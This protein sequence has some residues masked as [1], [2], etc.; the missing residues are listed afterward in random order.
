[1][2]DETRER[3]KPG[4]AAKKLSQLHSPCLPRYKTSGD[5]RKECVDF[6]NQTLRETRLPEPPAKKSTA[7]Y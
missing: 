2:H 7:H 6:R 4:H 5:Y 3:S 1:L